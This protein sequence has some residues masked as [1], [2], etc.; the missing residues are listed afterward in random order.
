M[1]D[2]I[3]ENHAT[4]NESFVAIF[5]GRRTSRMKSSKF[6]EEQIAFALW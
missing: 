4:Q 5:R 3:P 1:M 2:F 6:T